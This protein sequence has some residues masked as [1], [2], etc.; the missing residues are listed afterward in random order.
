M[1]LWD[2]QKKLE[3][4][5]FNKTMDP[6][7]RRGSCRWCH[8]HTCSQMKM[9]KVVEETSVQVGLRINK[10]K[11]KKLRAN[12]TLNATIYNGKEIIEVSKFISTKYYYK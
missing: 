1:G 11:T 8:A 3:E 2:H 6:H 10:A 12:T 4:M 5:G 7:G 9:E